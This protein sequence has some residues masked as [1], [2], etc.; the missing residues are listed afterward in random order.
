M[1]PLMP[2]SGF[3]RNPNFIR[4]EWA[5]Y[6]DNGRADAITAGWRGV[7]MAN[8]AL[9]DPVTSWNFFADPN[10][11]PGHLD[12]GASRTWYLAYAAGLGG[13]S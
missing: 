5:T 2:N 10:F 6:F 11:N 13:V 7:L 8:L 1:L 12:G 4:E 9:I 3:I